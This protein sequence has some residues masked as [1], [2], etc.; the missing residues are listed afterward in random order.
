MDRLMGAD[1]HLLQGG[2]EDLGIGLVGTHILGSHY[3]VETQA[4]SANGGLQRRRIGIGH[5]AD[6]HVHVPQEFKGIGVNGGIGPIL[7]KLPHVRC[8]IDA[9]V[10]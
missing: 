5:T 9:D 4:M 10:D 3:A 2:M 1:T 8:W 7:F 6:G